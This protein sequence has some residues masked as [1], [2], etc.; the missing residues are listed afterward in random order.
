VSQ[1]AVFRKVR[2][3]FGVS[4]NSSPKGSAVCTGAEAGGFGA[5]AVG[6]A[7][8]WTSAGGGAGVV[9]VAVP[10]GAG[11]AGGAGVAGGA[12]AP[13]GVAG[14]VWASTAESPRDMA[15]G[16]IAIARRR[17]RRGRFIERVSL[18]LADVSR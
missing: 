1:V 4:V 3:V 14:G 10:G 2:T 8:V 16:I 13:G 7:G 9:G 5:S 18:V 15:A 6:F 11:A 17:K 12:V